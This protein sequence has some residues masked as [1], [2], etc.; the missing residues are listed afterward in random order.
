[1]DIKLKKKHWIVRYKAYLAAGVVVI[2]LA[3]YTISLQFRPQVMHVAPEEVSIATVESTDFREYIES[4]GIVEPI[5]SLKVNSRINGYVARIVAEEGAFVEQGDTLLLLSNPDLLADLEEAESALRQQLITYRQ[6]EIEM[7]Q[8]TLT[9]RKQVLENQYE[10]QRLQDNF[11][12]S[13]EEFRMGIKSKAELRIAEQEYDYKKRAAELEQQSLRHDSTATV[14]RRQLID[15]A[16]RQEIEKFNRSRERLKETIVRAPASGQLSSL[17]IVPGQ[18]VNTGEE[19]G[20][21]K[22]TNRYKVRITPNEYYINR[23]T[24]GL[25]ARATLRGETYPMVVRRVVPEV[26]E[27]SFTAELAFSGAT[28][29][30]LRIGQTVRISIEIGSPEKT[31]AVPRGDFYSAT[32]GQWI[33]KLDSDGHRAVKTYIQLGRQNPKQ[34]EVMD[35]LKAG[36][37]VITSGY[38]RFENA[39]ELRVD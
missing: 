9:L 39:E 12:L 30:E 33:F 36:D 22:V 21:I 28:P 10:L 4:Q 6:E 19:I 27:N 5:M 8:K 3:A 31:L 2:A 16:R 13:E 20:E 35:G 37:R 23:I 17:Q 7:E 29:K 11:A 18:Q 26:K 1:M 15:A 32:G 24:A 38:A 25:P 14:L 34:Y